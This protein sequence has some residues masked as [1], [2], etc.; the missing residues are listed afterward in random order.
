[1]KRSA[2]TV[3]GGALIYEWMDSWHP[4]D[5]YISPIEFATRRSKW[6]NTFSLAGQYG[7]LAMD[8]LTSS[9]NTMIMDGDTTDWMQPSDFADDQA[10]PDTDSDDASDANLDDAQNDASFT[11]QATHD[12]AYVYVKLENTQEDESWH[13]ADTPL[14]FSFDIVDGGASS[15]EV[16]PKLDMS[17]APAEFILEIQEGE[18][19]LWVN[20][21][22]DPYSWQYA[23]QLGIDP[24]ELQNDT[25]GIFVPWRLQ[26]TNHQPVEIGHLQP[27]LSTDS[28]LDTSS[29]SSTYADWAMKE[30]ILELRIPWMLLGFMDPS[31]QFVWDYPTQ[32]N[33]FIPTKVDGIRITVHQQTWPKL[34]LLYRWDNWSSPVYKEREKLAYKQLQASFAP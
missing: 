25:N 20:K 16:Q 8:S 12:A 26:D 9:G 3:F 34:T 5:E 33:Q 10:G 28:V 2:E 4:Y 22:Y 23:E 15:W 18:A 21:A 17:D 1:M 27:I 11:I 32:I 24:D 19:K 7:L 14:W 31:Q 29:E 13:I 30:G 6:F